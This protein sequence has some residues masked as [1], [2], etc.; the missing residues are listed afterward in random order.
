[1]GSYGFNPYEPIIQYGRVGLG[2]KWADLQVGLQIATSSFHTVAYFV[3]DSITCL[4][5]IHQL[6][7][8]AIFPCYGHELNH[9]TF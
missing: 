3:I 1:M 6:H 4:V 8:N 7:Y 2:Y 9:S 5:E